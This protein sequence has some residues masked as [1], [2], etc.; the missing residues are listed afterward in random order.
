VSKVAFIG[1]G[2]MGSG[3]AERLLGAGHDVA[4][5]NRTV[6]K[7]DRLK[8][9]GARVGG[10][11]R[12]VSEGAEAVF[13]MTADDV[14]SREVWLGKD[15]V[16]AAN[17]AR[18]A[19]AIECSTLSHDWVLELAR[20]ASQRGLR[21]I[22]SP[23]TGLPAM[24]AAGTLTL[25]V[26]A[27]KQNLED[28]RALLEPLCERIIHFGAVGAGTVYKLTVNMIGAVQIASVAEGM[29]IAERAEL[30]LSQVADAIATGQA[31][32]PQV[33]R[34][35]RRIAD[36]NHDQNVVFTPQLRLKDVQYALALARK[37]DIGAPFATAAS[38]GLRELC[39]RGNAQANESKIIEIAR[40]RPATQS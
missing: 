15:G 40:T 16:F 34:N 27:S 29:A 4:V 24:A 18:G 37:L 36:E 12:E 28:A 14:A 22:D 2:M 25:L 23:V 21:Y 6:S 39:D 17:T 8:E 11:P 3:M 26:G 20:E 30:D 35:A 33:V 9:K 5:Y 38:K 10:T 19:F 31:A 7:A 1:L 13:A 32:S